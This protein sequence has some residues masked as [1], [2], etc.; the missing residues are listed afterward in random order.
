MS[1]NQL[2]IKEAREGLKSKKF[3]SVELTKAC[4]KQIKKHNP[5]LNAFI[6]VTEREALAQAKKTDDLISDGQDLPLLGIP[7][8]LK[9]LFSTKGV[10]TTAASKVL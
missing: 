3:S 2:T 6:T 1:L 8:A 10:K 4:L 7:I 9:D 5:S